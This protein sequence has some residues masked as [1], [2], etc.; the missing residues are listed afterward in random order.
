M[1]R[2]Q[3]VEAQFTV[4]GPAPATGLKWVIRDGALPAGLVLEE[5]GRLAGRVAADAEFGVYSFT[6]GPTIDGQLIT[7]A[8]YST[9]V[10][11]GRKKRPN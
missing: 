8:S 4:V 9:E 10:V 2:N 5:S 6:V 11:D 3:D 7:F 1:L